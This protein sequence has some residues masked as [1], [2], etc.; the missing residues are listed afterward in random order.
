MKHR[1]QFLIPAVLLASFMAPAGAQPVEENAPEKLLSAE[2]R[3]F[4]L[5]GPEA[6]KV[7]RRSKDL[8]VDDLNGDG[9]LDISTTNNERG[10]MEIYHQVAKPRDGG[11]RFERTEYALDR[12]VRSVTAADVDGDGRTDLVLA[13]SPANMAI[14]YQDANGRLQSPVS[15][16]I[17][18]D[19]VVAGDLD[20]KGGREL[21]AFAERTITI[22]PADKRGISLEPREVVYTTGLPA[23][24]PMLI[25]FDSDGRTDI[26][27][28]DANSF[29]A[30]VVRLQS[31]EGTFPAEFRVGSNVLRAAAPLAG[32]PNTPASVIAVQNSNRALVQLRLGE[33]TGRKP[34]A[35]DLELSTTFTVPFAPEAR[36]RRFSVAAGD[37]DGDGRTDL[38]MISP[39][40]SQ[41]RVLRQ[42]RG[43]SLEEKMFPTLQGIESARF[44]ESAAG[45]PPRIVLFSPEEKTLG[46]TSWDAATGTLPFP[47]VLPIT[48]NPVGATAWT[49][50]EKTYV[51]VLDKTEKGHALRRF[52]LGADGKLSDERPLAPEDALPG[53]K[54]KA[55]GLDLMDVN[56]DGALDMILFLDFG[57]S[58]ILTQ[59]AQGGF[60]PLAATSAVLDGLLSGT[61]PGL[62][63]SVDLGAKEG[64]DSMLAIKD[65]FARA[66]WIDKDQNVVVEEQFNGKDSTSRLV[67]AAVGSLRSADSREVVLLDRP[68]K[69]LTVH[70][71]ENGGAFT[72][73]I[74]HPLDDA[75]YS[76]VTLFD[77]DG[78]QRDDIILAADDR[79]SVIYTQPQ[80]L[81]LNTV[82]SHST[83]IEDGGYGQ[84]WG[85]NLPGPRATGIIAIE[86]SENYL[87]F[88]EVG[89][90][91]DGNPALNKFYGFK[92][93]DSEATIARRV[94]MDGQPEPREIVVS[95]LNDDGLADVVTLIHDNI[96][97]YPGVQKAP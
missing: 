67:D 23:S 68:S 69:L 84:V 55:L 37:V 27:Y 30:L 45:K 10:M 73:L 90:D 32:G 92:V 40:L 1:N 56:R 49:K 4:R 74:D 93:F 28:H 65:K 78:D 82:S 88:L 47:T 7:N 24:D 19:R 12:V 31:A 21:L 13:A 60:K 46:L 83:T 53:S 35:G 15:T 42:T 86:M 16:D 11:S 20:G 70:G 14:M 3:A 38:V 51:A 2:A 22:L 33:E 59:D 39:E 29:E 61:R 72:K 36:S 50:Q 77:L 87:D 91:A 34:A 95:D 81:N 76:T 94:N 25:D 8:L 52:T 9:L 43:G 44:L 63:K 80:G 17:P 57:A 48:G 89:K 97:I 79:L 58:R 62:L 26:V 66:T 54:V 6:Y 75:S 5:A 96:I 41:I 71:R 85:V 18:A 64:G